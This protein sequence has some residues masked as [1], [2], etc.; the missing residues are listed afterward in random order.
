MIVKQN[1]T[2]F[3]KLMQLNIKSKPTLFQVKFKLYPNN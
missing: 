1:L 3:H 2:C